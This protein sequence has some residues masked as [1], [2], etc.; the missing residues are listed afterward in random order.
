MAV[1]HDQISLKECCRP[2]WDRTRNLLITSRT[3]ETPRPSVPGIIC[4]CVS[5]SNCAILGLVTICSKK[6]CLAVLW[7]GILVE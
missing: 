5:Y 1:F 6:F 7:Y 4:F 3:T 2:G